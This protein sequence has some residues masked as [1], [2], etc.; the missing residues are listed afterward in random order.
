MQGESKFFKAVSSQGEEQNRDLPFILVLD[1]QAPSHF[2]N[3]CLKRTGPHAA[4][5]KPQNV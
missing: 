3:C 1:F 2:P 5:K 4:S